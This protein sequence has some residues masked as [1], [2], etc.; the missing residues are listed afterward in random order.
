MCSHPPFSDIFVSVLPVKLSSRLTVPR[1]AFYVNK[2][3]NS[4]EWG[5][6]HLKQ[7]HLCLAGLLGYGSHQLHDF[8]LVLSSN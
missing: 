6:V 3:S 1:V 4:Y 7:S 5:I 8:G 2:E